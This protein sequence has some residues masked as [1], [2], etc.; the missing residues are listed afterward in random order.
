MTVARSG[1]RGGG[2]RG[3]TAAAFLACGLLSCGGA[4]KAKPHSAERPSLAG[5]SEAEAVDGPVT[6]PPGV[7][8]LGRAR[9]YRQWVKLEQASP[10]VAYLK[11]KLI[12]EQ[13]DALLED[14]DLT[15]P[16]EF[17]ATFEPNF[18][19]TSEQPAPSGES[20]NENE[21]E[22][23]DD[24][25]KAATDS[26]EQHFL[27]AFSLPLTRYAPESYERLGFKY[28]TSNVYE[29]GNC[30]VTPALG[31]A[32]ARL[33]CGAHRDVT[34][35]LY[36]YLA[37][38]LPLEPLSPAPLFVELRPQP[39]KDLWGPA[40]DAGLQ[41]L[42]GLAENGGNT[43][44]LLED[45]TLS[46]V[47]EVDAWVASAETLRFEGG[48]NERGEL[49]ASVTVALR[50]P[51]PWLVE[52]SLA[53]AAKIGGAPTAFL[54]LPKDVSAAWYSYGMPAERTAALQSAV[55]NLA[56][57]AFQEFGPGNRLIAGTLSAA[58]AKTIDRFV[59][60]LISLLDSQCL[61]AEQS[62]F[63]NIAADA[64]E[65]N[66]RA[67]NEP[68]KIMKE[69]Q[70]APLVPLDVLARAALGQYLVAMPS[71]ARCGQLTQRWVDLLVSLLQA[72]PAKQKKDL[73][74][75]VSSRK[76]VALKG[77]P[78]ATVTRISLTKQAV[79]QLQK[80]LTPGNG[81]AQRYYNYDMAG[82]ALNRWD[83]PQGPMVLS[84]IVVPAAD[85]TG[86]DWIGFGLDEKQLVRA[87]VQATHP[88]AGQTLAERG[89]LAPFL[90]QNPS[91]L[92]VQSF[93]AQ[94]KLLALVGGP[95]LGPA[96]A[97]L[98]GLFHGASVVSTTHVRLRGNVAQAGVS[99]FLSKQ[100]LDGVR[101]ILSWD[102]E[103]LLELAQRMK[104]A[105]SVK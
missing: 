47:K 85:T 92:S 75:V 8:A 44:R 63:A 80:E 93:E 15:Q 32:R 30:V 62:V 48:P 76:K 57:T 64:S 28:W 102:I 53:S 6:A 61:R 105:E 3:G 13:G 104:E 58:D 70:P 91:A 101:Q 34:R 23:G 42:H 43:R 39:L 66:A 46:V 79:A 96:L 78:P 94:S 12:E 11:K 84:L 97:G 5:A 38:G 2:A 87:L 69:P 50:S 16:V 45:L 9:D 29:R 52:S 41:A 55:V 82:S 10:G 72:L 31:S 37:R 100:G 19:R 35:H 24:G 81:A 98:Q 54:N 71:A 49:E 89:D 103:H 1:V 67:G 4:P 51:Q 95:E 27:A 99:Y 56:N 65:I 83:A 74:F 17:V 21:N 14:W 20:E 88:V 77:L 73:P 60:E 26:F 22:N 59:P 68:V 18:R 36:G 40:R 7:I 25:E 86:S 90:A 33:I